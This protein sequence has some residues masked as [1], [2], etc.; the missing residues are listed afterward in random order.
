[1][2]GDPITG[3]RQGDRFTD[4]ADARVVQEA[5]ASVKETRGEL[6]QEL[7]AL[8]PCEDRRPLHHDPFRQEQPVT[9]AGIGARRDPTAFGLPEQLADHHRP[10]EAVSDLRVSAAQRY[11]EFI[12]RRGQVEKDGLHEVLVCLPFR[13]QHGGEEP[14]GPGARRGNVVRTDV[15]G[16]PTDAVRRK[17]DR[18]RLCHQALA[19]EID[20]RRVHADAGSHQNTRVRLC[21]A[22]EHPLEDVVG[23][24]TDGER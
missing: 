24:F 11:P 14:A 4:D 16:V 17:G 10:I 3:L 5:R 12:A 19:A 13:K 9:R 8:L 6:L 21:V 1:M 22:F 2:H 20:D 23:E 18:V 15:Y 7:I